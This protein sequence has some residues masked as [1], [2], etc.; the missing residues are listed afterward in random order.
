VNIQLAER[1][2]DLVLHD[3]V[4]HAVLDLK[5]MVLEYIHGLLR[6]GEFGVELVDDGFVHVG[7]SGCADC[8]VEF[9]AAVGAVPAFVH[10][11][12]LADPVAE[13]GQRHPDEYVFG[14]GFALDREVFYG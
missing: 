7:I 14:V 6:H 1:L 4:L 8:I 10:D 3:D 5:Q 11:E 13:E 9:E 12:T 2:E